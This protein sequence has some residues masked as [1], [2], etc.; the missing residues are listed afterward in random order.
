MIQVYVSCDI[1]AL[2]C[3]EVQAQV[4][5]CFQVRNHRRWVISVQSAL[6]LYPLLSNTM[7]LSCLCSPSLGNHTRTQRFWIIKQQNIKSGLF[8]RLFFLIAH[9]LTPPSGSICI[10]DILHRGQREKIH[11]LRSS[12]GTLRVFSCYTTF[13]LFV[14]SLI[15][16][17]EAFLW[18]HDH[19]VRELYSSALFSVHLIILLRSVSDGLIGVSSDFHSGPFV[20]KRTA[21]NSAQ[22]GS[23]L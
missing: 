16:Y 19:V 2:N 14:F 6:W 1:K 22:I 3:T 18:R 4:H 23:W 15:K 11:K 5:R 17:V 13:F 20:S 7:F 12:L 21:H 8:G 9:W 10:T